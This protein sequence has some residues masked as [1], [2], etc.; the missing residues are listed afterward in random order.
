MSGC[1]RLTDKEVERV[2]SR[3]DGKM[4]VLVLV[5]LT[6]GTRI[7][8]S[9]AMTVGN[10]KG[11]FVTIQGKKKGLKQTYPIPQTV[12]DSVNALVKIYR[13]S[14][15]NVTDDTPLFCGIGDACMSRQNASQQLRKIFKDA[16]LDGKVNTHSLRK[17]FVTKIYEATGKDIIR[18]RLFSRHSSINSLI[19]YI[20]TCEDTGLIND[21]GW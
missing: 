17:S 7:S 1:R 4:K 10:F 3:V 21:L 15:I 8:E 20:E 19:H 6:Y 12:K 14:G 5:G 13:G 18:T 11:E 16:S 2:L 9:L